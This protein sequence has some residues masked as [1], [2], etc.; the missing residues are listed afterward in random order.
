MSNSLLANGAGGDAS[1]IDGQAERPNGA[2]GKSDIE[3][4]AAMV[5]GSELGSE[6]VSNERERISQSFRSLD[7]TPTRP[8]APCS[9]RLNSG[10]CHGSLG[11]AAG[12]AWGGRGFRDC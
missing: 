3:G 8:H 10:A 2:L 12:F 9:L 6:R 7:A 11:N 5:A 4:K 1:D